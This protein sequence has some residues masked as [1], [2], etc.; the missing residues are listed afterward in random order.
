MKCLPD[1]SDAL[2]AHLNKF[3]GMFCRLALVYHLIEAAAAGKYPAKQISEH[4]A[5]WPPP[6]WRSFCSRTASGSIRKPSTTAAR[7]SMRD[8]WPGTSSPKICRPSKNGTSRGTITSRQKPQ[9]TALTMDA[10][11]VANWVKPE[12]AQNRRECLRLGN[13][14]GGTPEVRL[15]GLRPSMSAGRPI[16]QRFSKR[17]KDPSGK[18][19]LMGLLDEFLKAYQKRSPRAQQFVAFVGKGRADKG[20]RLTGH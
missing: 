16:G 8:G 12:D 2:K 14:P 4:T 7:A 1:T 19:E 18:G 13:Q 6:S 17:C 5:R 15:L 11:Y 9:A 3:E 20:D 10:L